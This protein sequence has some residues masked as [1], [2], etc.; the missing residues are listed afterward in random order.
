MRRCVALVAAVLVLAGG[1]RSGGDTARLEDDLRAQAEAQN[2]LRERLGELEEQIAQLRAAVDDEVDATPLLDELD[3]R[4]EQMSSELVAE[5]TAREDALNDVRGAVAE[6]R[7]TLSSLE[8][9]IA[10]LRRELGDLRSRHN[11][12]EQRFDSHERHPPG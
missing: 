9:A 8:S 12:L 4:L 1:C 10:E 11:L 5:T 3:Q 7:E 6:V 2:T